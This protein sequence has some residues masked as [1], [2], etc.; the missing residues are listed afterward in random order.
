[1]NGLCVNSKAIE[2]ARGCL[3]KGNIEIGEAN[4]YNGKLRSCAVAGKGL[5]PRKKRK[6]RNGLVDAVIP[7]NV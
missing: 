7:C 4:G 6:K 2:G 3:A 1:M 5:T